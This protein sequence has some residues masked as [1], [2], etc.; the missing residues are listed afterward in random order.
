MNIGIIGPSPVPYAFG[1]IE[2]LLAG[3]QEH[4]S[5]ATSHR[6]ELIKLPSR[7]HTFWEI[8]ESY[9]QFWRLDVSHF[10][11]VISVKYPGWM[12]RHPQH[13]CY[14]AHRLRGLYDSYPFGLPT[15]VRSDSAPVRR[16]VE[17]IDAHPASPVDATAEC[18]HLLDRVHEAEA[19]VS[20]DAFAFPG[21]L[22]RRIVRFLDEHALSPHRIRRF[23]AI[24]ATV[25]SRAGYFPP[26]VAVDVIHPPSHL[27]GFA[28]TGH[29]YL[30]TTSRLDGPKRIDLLVRAMSLAKAPEI[31][32][33]AGTGPEERALRKL[34]SDDR[35]IEFLGFVS[36]EAL[37]ELYGGASAVLYVPRE[38]DYGLVTIEAMMS[39]KPVVTCADSGGPLEFV[40]DGATG[41]IAEPDPADIARKI[42]ALSADPAGAA[43][44]GDTGY[45]RV[46]SLTWERT[47]GALLGEA[48][49]SSHRTS[50]LRATPRA[51]AIPPRP[52]LTVAVPYAVHPPIGGGQQRMFHLYREVARAFD[53]DVVSLGPVD[54]AP[55]EGDIAPGLREIRVPKSIR[56]QEEE[57][58]IARDA[59]GVPIADAV[60][61]LLWK[62]S[63]AYG[64]QLSQSM[65]RAQAVVASHPYW[66][67]AIQ[68]LRDRQVLIYEAHNV[69]YRLKEEA[70]RGCGSSVR[71]LVE[72]VRGVEADA[73]H[74]ASLV[75]CCSREDAAELAELYDIDAARI[76]IAPNGVDAARIRF[77]GRAARARRKADMA[78]GGTRLAVL[79]GSWHPPNLEAARALEPVARALPGVNFV[80]AG[81]QCIPLADHPWPRNVGLMGVVD[82]ET[83]AALL[84]VA[85]VALNP[86]LGGSGTN[87]K[88]AT[89]LAAGVP[90]ITTPLG[91][92]GYDLIDGDEALIAPIDA[93]PERIARLMSDETLVDRLTSSG[94]RLVEQRYNWRTIGAEMAAAYRATLGGPPGSAE[95][96]DDLIERVS[97]EILEMGALD[98]HSL[99]VRVAGA[100]KD[101]APAKPGTGAAAQV[102]IARR[103]K[104]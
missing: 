43:A 81:S 8:V 13:T 96:F 103:R 67:P 40:E 7:E 56:H 63:P 49:P 84:S 51:S 57:D 100:L 23:C 21:P 61:P 6:A 30:F 1:G 32:K 17:F 29:G 76:R 94:R 97:A 70:L 46:R 87:V 47:V 38:E 86:M 26:G 4:I 44:M 98:D 69:E 24:S 34:A 93:F 42:D 33:V 28:S 39:R 99:M 95:P 104:P 101:M 35:R 79:V 20:P 48:V 55:F 62:L 60:I 72:V 18:F 92:R 71:A 9:R 31:L 85:D 12:A 53:V 2:A 77:T 66:L 59:A 65:K 90:V 80:L 10:D 64:D 22:I 74:S 78:L 16:L 54:S 102:P 19:S 36:D 37:V 83:L 41:L 91:A 11:R 15:E 88:M 68:S 73:C 3:L 52:L 89:Y 82:D 45:E 14:M 5:R 50:P 27:S 25:A 75:F 58:R